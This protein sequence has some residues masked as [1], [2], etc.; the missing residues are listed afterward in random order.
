MEQSGR[1]DKPFSF[2]LYRSTRFSQWRQKEPCL[3]A[4]GLAVDCHPRGNGNACTRSITICTSPQAITFNRKIHLLLLTFHFF[5]FTIRTG[6]LG[7][8]LT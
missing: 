4:K 8:G 3:L 6:S 1:E 2:P 7:S 5:H